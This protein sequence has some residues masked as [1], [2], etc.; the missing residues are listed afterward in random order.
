[1]RKYYR[2][3]RRAFECTFLAVGWEKESY[4]KIRFFNHLNKQ[5]RKSSVEDV[6]GQIK[7]ACV[8]ARARALNGLGVQKNIPNISGIIIPSGYHCRPEQL[9]Q[10]SCVKR[11]LPLPTGK[12]VAA[13]TREWHEV[14]RKPAPKVWG[15]ASAGPRP[16]EFSGIPRTSQNLWDKLPKATKSW[17]KRLRRKARRYTNKVPDFIGSSACAQYSCKEGGRTRYAMEHST[18]EPDAPLLDPTHKWFK[19]PRR[20][21]ALQR[22]NE[23][24]LEPSTNPF[25]IAPSRVVAVK[26]PGKVRMVTVSDARVVG[27]AHRIRKALFDAVTSRRGGG[28]ALKFLPSILPFDRRK[29]DEM[30]KRWVYSADLSKAT[31]GLSHEW[32]S[33][34]CRFLD[35]PSSLIFSNMKVIDEDSNIYEVKRGAFMGLPASWPLLSLSHLIICERVDPFG[36]FWLKGDDMIAYWRPCQWSFY[37]TLMAAT[38]MTVNEGKSFKAAS[39]GTFC[40]GLYELRDE[41]FF[42]KPSM[43]IRGFV[44]VSSKGNLYD[45]L[46]TCMDEAIRRG[47]SRHRVWTVARYSNRDALIFAKERSI[48]WSLPRELG[49]LGLPPESPNSLVPALIRR[50]FWGNLDKGIS[51]DPTSYMPQKPFGQKWSKIL[52][53]IEYRS[54]V[55]KPCVHLPIIEGSARSALALLE[56]GSEPTFISKGRFLGALSRRWKTVL[57]RQTERSDALDLTWGGMYSALAHLAPTSRSLLDVLGHCGPVCRGEMKSRLAE[58]SLDDPATN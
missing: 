56:L 24:L 38:G 1:M 27:S 35:L 3:L 52:S 47:V 40:E 2:Q 14:A 37:K 33:W 46:A 49:G 34:I 16:K 29:A 13:A 54:G 20:A 23:N 4:Q 32:L 12:E 26:E 39:Y 18:L 31:D 10:I 48:R 7:A 55:A 9:F 28:E 22:R 36:L 30:G 45:N 25:P 50:I 57:K 11:A 53:R 41:G 6:F 17:L 44:H 19:S 43:S 42:L 5:L 21:K 8:L 58:L 15:L 51:R